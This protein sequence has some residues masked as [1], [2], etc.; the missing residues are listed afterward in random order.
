[1][2]RTICKYNVDLNQMYKWKKSLTWLDEVDGQHQLALLTSSKGKANKTIQS[3]KGCI[4]IAHY[5]AIR[6]MVD[7]LGGA[8]WHVLC[9]DAHYRIEDNIWNT[10]IMVCRE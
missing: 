10:S 9:N 2:K 6:H 7:T 5:G 4:D 8:S 3:G 1:M